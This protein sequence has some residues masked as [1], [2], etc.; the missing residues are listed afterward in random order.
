MTARLVGDK[1]KIMTQHPSYASFL[2]RLW[3][4]PAGDH[5][6]LAQAEHIPSGEQRYFASLDELCRFI[7]AQAAGSPPAAGGQGEPVDRPPPDN[8]GG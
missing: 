2:V 4:A 5:D 8:F 3:R 1:L 7:R 6:W